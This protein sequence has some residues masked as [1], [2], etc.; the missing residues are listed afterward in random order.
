MAITTSTATPVA[1]YTP[2]TGITSSQRALSGIPRAQLKSVVNE[3]SWGVS[4]AGNEK[5]LTMTTTLDDSYAYVLVSGFMR[6]V[7]D[8]TGDFNYINN[9]ARVQVTASDSDYYYTTMTNHINY[10]N[11]QEG[12]AVTLGSLQVR[13]AMSNGLEVDEKFY[14]LDQVENTVI[15]P[16]SENAIPSVVVTLEDPTTIQDAHT[17]DLQLTLIQYD[18]EQAYHFAVNQASLVRI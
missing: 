15:F 5:R 12:I 4:G 10:N 8:A 13:D 16:F 2:Y 6:V 9:V 1:L 14:S 18:L 11:L 7:N 3:Y 17:V